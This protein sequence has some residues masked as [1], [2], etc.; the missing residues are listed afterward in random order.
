MLGE[1]AHSLKRIEEN[2][3]QGGEISEGLLKYTRKGNEGFEDIS[4]T[5]LLDDS[6]EMVQYKINVQAM[7]VSRTF[8]P[9]FT[10][11]GN[12]TQMQEVFFN[13]IDNSF[14]AMMERKKVLA[15]EGYQPILEIS[16]RR[17]DGKMILEISDNGMGVKKEDK[18]KLYTPFF[19]TKVEQKKGTGLGLYVI[20]K[21]IEDN[22]Q[23]KVEFIS[24]YEKGS[25]TRIVI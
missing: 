9:S 21:I 12:F 14:Y 2:V 11:H 20:K 24:E 4:L 25:M 7:K 17:I 18:K 1:V 10:F 16:A 3:K 8:D 6:L 19:S 5:K 13:I 15:Q 23:G 22:H